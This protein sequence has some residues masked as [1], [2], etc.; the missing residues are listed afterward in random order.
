MNSRG[1]FVTLMLSAVLGGLF[2]FFLN[3]VSFGAF[4]YVLASVFGIAFVGFLHY[5]IWGYGLSKDLAQE[6][7]D[8]LRQQQRELDVQTPLD[9]YGIQ[10]RRNFPGGPDERIQ[11]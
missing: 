9:P 4:S 10:T 8:F 7:A 3:G 5:A 2:L 1:N 6:R 11:R